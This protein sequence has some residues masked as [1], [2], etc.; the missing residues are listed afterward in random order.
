MTKKDYIKHAKIISKY[1]EEGVTFDMYS[2]IEDLSDTFKQDNPRFDKER[3]LE[4][5]YEQN[6]I[7]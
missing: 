3:F 5:C 7:S 6:T 2:Y 1:T 4:A